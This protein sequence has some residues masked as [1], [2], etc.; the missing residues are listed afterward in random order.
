MASSGVRRVRGNLH[1]GVDVVIGKA[2]DTVAGHQVDSRLS[3]QAG[4]RVTNHMQSVV[5][6]LTAPNV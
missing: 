2:L 3:V 5:D 6:T 1:Y 4:L